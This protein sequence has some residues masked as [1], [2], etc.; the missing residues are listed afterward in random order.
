MAKRFK[1]TINPALL[2][3]ARDT[4]GYDLPVAAERLKIADY[5]LASWEAGD[6]QPSIS[7]LRKM[8]ALYK[9]PL[10]VLYL[11]E[12]PTDFQAMHDF[13]R[14]PDFGPR[15]FSP[16]LSLEVRRAQ[17]RRQLAIELYEENL[18]KP[19]SFTLTTTLRADPEAVGEQIRAAFRVRR[20]QQSR[21]GNQLHAFREWRTKIEEAGVLVFQASRIESD[22]ASGFALWAEKFPLIVV[23]RKDVYPRRTFSLLHELAHLMLRQSGVSELDVDAPR[24]AA[25]AAVE[26]FCNHVAAA[27][28]IPRA[29]FL[30]EPLL[31]QR[32]GVQEWPDDAIEVLSGS[33]NTSREGVVRRLL[34]F[35][36]VTQDFYNRKRAQ[37]AAEFRAQRQREREGRGDQGIPR[38]MP[39]ETIADFGRPFIRAVIENYH[40]DRIT[41]SDVSGYLGVKVRHIPVIAS[42]VGMA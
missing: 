7:Q 8:A 25:D 40:Q 9:R 27:T 29:A 34:T 15:R 37:Y 11:P 20:D 32:P 31:T 3:W 6:D 14:L 30:A 35:G 42:Q 10:A 38:N 19:A 18:A 4:A 17:Q 33:Y 1:A 28:L 23:N 36:R 26:V 24:P 16:G 22:E 41:L 13:R 21:W 39:L 12:P 5:V 2:T